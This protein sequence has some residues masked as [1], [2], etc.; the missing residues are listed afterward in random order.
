MYESVVN[1]GIISMN[2]DVKKITLKSTDAAGNAT[3][4]QFY[5]KN[6]NFI[7]NSKPKTYNYFLPFDEPS[8]INTEGAFAPKLFKSFE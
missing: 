4:L 8:L 6:K 5:L 1:N 3:Y 7:I 2:D